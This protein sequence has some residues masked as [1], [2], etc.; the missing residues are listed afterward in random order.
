MAPRTGMGRLLPR[1]N[2]SCVNRAFALGS[3]QA[4]YLLSNLLSKRPPSPLTRWPF[5]FGPH[6]PVCIMLCAFMSQADRDRYARDRERIRAR[7]DEYRKKHRERWD[8]ERRSRYASDSV[9]QT[10]SI[11]RTMIQRCTDVNHDAYPYYGA[12]GVSVCDRWL[13][14]FED[15]VSDVGLRPKGLTLDR[16]DGAKGYERANVRWASRSEQMHNRR[17]PAHSI[18]TCSCGI[19]TR[20]KNRDA[21][22]RYAQKKAA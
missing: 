13:K 21:V 12:E 3:P 19:C 9:I 17:L 1:K 22:R 2:G 4:I 10:K 14:S 7:H 15:F 8:R 16:I 18:P 20:C 11:W 5:F 6:A